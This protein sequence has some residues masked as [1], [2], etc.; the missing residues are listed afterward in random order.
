[1]IHFFS[2]NTGT[3]FA[4]RVRDIVRTIP[5]GETRTYKE[6][7]T[8]AGS[9]RAARAVGTLMRNNYLEDVPCHRVIRSDGRL[10]GYNRGG[11]EKKK[12]LLTL[13]GFY[14]N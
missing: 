14:T 13:E 7:A 11:I 3:V 12:E 10:G 1:M 9:P 2:M 6:V 5:K 4:E 8:A